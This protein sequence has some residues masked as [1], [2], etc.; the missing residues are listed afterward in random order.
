MVEISTSILSVE[1]EK[2]MKTFYNLEASKT[3]Y[4]HIDVMDGKFVANNTSEQMI[5]YAEN[6]RQISNLPLDIHLMVENPKEYIEQYMPLEPS[7]ITI[8][9]EAFK[10][11]NELFETIKKIKANGVKCGLAIKPKTNLEEIYE[12]LPYIHMILV[13]TVEPGK[14]G[15]ELIPDTIKKIEQLKKYITEKDI[16][17]YIEADGG[18]NLETI[19]KLKEAGIDIAVVG[20]A[21]IKTENYAE[22]IANLKQI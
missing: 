6:I 12:F 21:I 13:M 22:T 15:Q 16:D 8:H 20:N 3:D 19:S 4:F 9:Y 14:G 11:K 18:I 7:F 10:E 5:E 17:I 2:A 1:K